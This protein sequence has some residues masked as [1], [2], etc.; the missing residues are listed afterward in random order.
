MSLVNPELVGPKVSYER[1]RPEKTLLYK[2]VQENLLTFYRAAETEYEGG[3]PDFVK[4]EFDEYLKCGILAHGFVRARCEQCGH[5]KLVAYSCKRRG[6]CPSCGARRMAEAAAHL[7]DEVFPP[8]AMRQ[9]VVSF[10]YQLRFLMAKHPKVMTEMLRITYRAIET[11]LIKKA[12]LKR[13]SKARAGAVTFVQRFGGSLNLN[14][15]LHQIYL[16]G[17]YTFEDGKVQF[18]STKPPIKKE[19]E[20]VLSQIAS[21][22]V[23]CLEKRGLIEKE[24]NLLTLAPEAAFDHIQGAS[25]TYQIAFGKRKGQKAL[26]LQTLPNRDKGR[27]SEFLARH[28]GFSL[29]AGVACQAHERKKLERICRYVSRSSVSEERL[30]LNARGQVVYKLKK[31]YDNGTTHIVL[32][33]LDFLSRLAALIPRPRVNLTRYHGVFAANF[34]YRGLVVPK[35]PKPEKQESSDEGSKT[36]RMNW[37]RR[38]RRVFQIDVETCP[39]CGG[40]VKVISAIDDPRVIKKILDHLGLETKAPKPFPPRAPPSLSSRV[41]DDFSDDGTFNQNFPADS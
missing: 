37:A 16:D 15:H 1:H 12:G 17:V 27:E 41:V 3:L 20:K 2:L 35:R 22:V 28:S 31:S 30:S 19:L 5:E 18:H 38:L 6:F 26:T 11:H 29:H 13:S 40:S 39:A 9:W 8:Q 32:D 24:Q 23:R 25:I 10:P 14:V 7:V 21:R 33:P 4:K 34:K 36:S